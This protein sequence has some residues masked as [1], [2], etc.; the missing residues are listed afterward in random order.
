MGMMTSDEQAALDL[1]VALWNAFV[2]LPCH[3]PD[4]IAEFRHKLHDIQRLI[5]VRPVRLALAQ[6]SLEGDGEPV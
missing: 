4:D 5:M 6:V 3:H 1:T 2:A